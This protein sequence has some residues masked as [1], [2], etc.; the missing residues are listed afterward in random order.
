MQAENEISYEED[1]VDYNDENDF[2]DDGFGGRRL[3]A[4]RR[5]N[6]NR[7]NRNARSR[8]NRNNQRN[9][10]GNNR[11][12]QRGNK[13]GRRGGRVSRK[14]LAKKRMAKGLFGILDANHNKNLSLKEMFRPFSLADSNYDYNVSL[15]E[16]NQFI[17]KAKKPICR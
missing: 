1:K 13:R 6:S 5:G 15:I 3:R 17:S 7:G 8:G 10:D 2:E 4:N 12:T 16:F 9:R 14:S 11:R